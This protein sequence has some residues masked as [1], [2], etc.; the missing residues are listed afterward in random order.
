ML[1]MAPHVE[2]RRTVIFVVESFAFERVILLVILMNCVTLAMSPAHDAPSTILGLDV[3]S[4][5]FGIL[6][7]YS[8]EQL[9]KMFAY[10][11]HSTEGSFHRDAWACFESVIVAASW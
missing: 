5:D 9:L 8:V 7:V 1:C 11:F 3:A 4:L 6:L 2:P 10:S